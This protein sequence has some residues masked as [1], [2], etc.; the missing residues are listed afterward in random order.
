MRERINLFCLSAW[1][2]GTSGPDNE[3]KGNK[4]V[5]RLVTKNGFLHYKLVLV[6]L[7][8]LLGSGAGGT[9]HTSSSLL[10]SSLP[11]SDQHSE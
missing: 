9:G 4:Y 8:T 2:A 7:T 5:T 11:R 3:R 1:F 6:I 10:F